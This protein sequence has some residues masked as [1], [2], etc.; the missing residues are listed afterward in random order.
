MGYV[1]WTVRYYEDER[2]LGSEWRHFRWT[3]RRAAR[4]FVLG[5]AGPH[6]EEVR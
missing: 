6:R 4:R 5:L 2:F 1:M 3:A